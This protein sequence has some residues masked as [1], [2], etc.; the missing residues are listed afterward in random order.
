MA[1]KNYALAALRRLQ[2]GSAPPEKQQELLDKIVLQAT[3]AGDVIQHL[4]SL[5]RK[6]EVEAQT[7]DLNHLVADTLKL[8]ETDCQWRDIRLETKLATDLPPVVGDAIQIQQVILKLVR[9]SIQELVHSVGLRAEVYASAHQYLETFDP[10]RPGCLVLDV[11]M[12]GMSGRALQAKLNEMHARIPIVFISS[13]GDIPMAVKAGAVDFVQ[14]P[15]HEQQLLDSINEVLRR[16]AALRHGSVDCGEFAERLQ[17]L[18]EREREVMQLAAQGL[19]SKAIAQQ[20]N[21]SPRTVEVHRGHLLDMLAVG[22]IAE[23]M[24]LVNGQRH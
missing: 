13:Y 5:G 4:R 19:S 22:S 17:W 11:R 2:E 18:T 12:A 7:L 1:I 8:V 14:K 3:R 6:H 20:L 16:D 24:H 15:Y 10:E 9:D 23:L 21:I